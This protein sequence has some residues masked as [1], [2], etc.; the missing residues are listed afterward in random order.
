MWVDSL[1]P[2]CWRQK[3]IA[4]TRS[5]QKHKERTT[6]RNIVYALKTLINNEAKRDILWAET[7]CV[8]SHAELVKFGYTIFKEDFST[9]LIPDVDCGYVLSDSR[10]RGAFQ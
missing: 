4:H 1:Y 9:T 3:D 7:V 8:T 5:K 6:R 2:Q 10:G